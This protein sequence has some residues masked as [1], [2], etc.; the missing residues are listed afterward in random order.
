MTVKSRMA[1][2]TLHNLD[3]RVT[4]LEQWKQAHVE[5]IPKAE[6]RIMLQIGNLIDDKLNKRFGWMS[7]ILEAVG[8]AVIVAIVL[9]VIG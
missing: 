1:E 9:A 5:G 8:I 4:S 6:E 2:P 7:R 3:V